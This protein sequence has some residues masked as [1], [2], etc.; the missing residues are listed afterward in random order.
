MILGSMFAF[1][2]ASA[3]AHPSLSWA[4]TLVPGRPRS[5]V[6]SLLSRAGV[7]LPHVRVEPLSLPD[8]FLASVTSDRPLYRHGLDA[9]HLLVAQPL[10]PCAEVVLEVSVGGTRLATRPVQL[11][12]RGLG[13]VTLRE[14]PV[15]EVSVRLR[16]APASWPSCTFT[17]A[18]YK[19]AP[20]VAVLTSRSLERSRLSFT[21][22]LESYGAPVSGEVR[23][24][25]HD[26][27]RRIDAATAIAKEGEVSSVFELRGEGPHAIVVQLASDASK[28]AAAP[29]I[30]SRA[31]ERE[32]TVVSTL[33]AEVTAALLPGP[34]SSLVRGLYLDEGAIRSSPVRLERVDA[35]TAR[36]RAATPLE[37]LR[38]VALDPR[39]PPRRPGAV[40]VATAQHPAL[41]D[42]TY[43]DAEAHFQAGRIERA[44]ELF[45]LG[46]SLVKGPPHPNYAYF[47][48]CAHARLGR[49]DAALGALADAVREGWTDFAHLAADSDLASLRGNPTYE[50]FATGGVHEAV[51]D[52][53]AAGQVVEFAVPGPVSLLAVGVFANGK[54]WEGWAAML[55]PSELAPSVSVQGAAE[56]GKE[57]TVRIGAGGSASVSA[58][59]VVKDARLPSTDTPSSRLAGAMKAFVGDASKLLH[60]GEPTE[61]LQVPSPPA[62]LLPIQL[63]PFNPP[64]PFGSGPPPSSYDFGPPPAF[65]PPPMPGP[66]PGGFGPPPGGFG[67]AP[68]PPPAPSPWA[69]ARGVGVSAPPPA[70]APMR[71]PAKSP[72]AEPVR[73]ETHDQAALFRARDEPVVLFAGFVPLVRGEGALPVQL[74]GEPADYVVEVFVSTGLDWAATEHRFRA[75]RPTFVSV[76]APRFVHASDVALGRVFVQCRSAATITIRKGG[77]PVALVGG[78]SGRELAPGRHELSFVATPGSFEVRLDAGAESETVSV[79]IDEPGKLRRLARAVQMLSPG[80]HLSRA[81]DPSIRALRVL[82]GVDRPL[83]ALIDATADYGHSCCEQTAAKILAAC[84]M[85]ALADEPA[86]RSRAESIIVAGVEREERMWLRGQGFRTYPDSP[87]YPDSSWGPKTARHLFQLELLSSLSPSRALGRAMERG[88]EMA[89]DAAAAY[90]LSWPPRSPASCEDGY[91]ALRFGGDAAQASRLVSARASAAAGLLSAP[92]GRVGARAETAYAA[93]AL[94]AAGGDRALAL[95]LANAV[96]AE[97][98]AEGRLYSTVDSVAALALVSELRRAGV[99]G[100][101]AVEVNGR[102]L[103]LAQA[104]NITEVESVRAANGTVAVEVLREVAEDWDRFASTVPVR[105][106]LEVQGRPTRRLRALDAAELVVKLENGYQPGDLCWVCLPDALSRVVG[107]GQVKL[108]SVDFAGA[109]EVRIPLAATGATFDAAGEPGSARYAVCV[110]NMFEEERAGNPGLLD[111]SVA[112]AEGSSSM[113][114]ALKALALGLART[115]RS[116]LS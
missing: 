113:T 3:W 61:P 99:C 112:P 89:R 4:R 7:D 71:A 60:V 66:A 16:D 21:L 9:A 108:F 65:G 25:L 90:D 53:V 2:P 78:Q 23:L 63:P 6:L 17:V 5:R 67:P 45:E 29:V 38:V 20:L 15:G 104:V 31:A 46:K 116:A 27:G 8:A 64:P 110:R 80:E 105:V 49:T 86:R 44:L 14:L 115:V 11:D 57:L 41:V 56:P 94:L 34:G 35:R 40:D 43:R 73:P 93:A 55:A 42:A 88:L 32:P 62:P 69:Q 24:E 77:I 107:G 76:D 59:V 114:A 91:A 100:D 85:F 33:G 92:L 28:T 47:I 37:T 96:L 74:G 10:S 19:L 97:L 13:A 1:V 87:P 39:V 30:G 36:L 103:A 50:A 101:A 26:G 79:R 83:R 18:E 54:P 22:S 109:S 81:S 48:A 52:E 111:V 72:A 68:A 84:A 75:D 98:G 102:A 70:A 106:A 82:P 58:Y 51:H 95:R 12:E